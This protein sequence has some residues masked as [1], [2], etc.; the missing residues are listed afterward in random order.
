[1]SSKHL[2]ANP[3]EEDV[4]RCGTKRRLDTISGMVPPR[5][6]PADIVLPLKVT[7][8]ETKPAAN[9]LLSWAERQMEA[10]WSLYRRIHGK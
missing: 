8:S 9:L 3:K 5:R 10:C 7:R 1:M 4:R 2:E 6:Q